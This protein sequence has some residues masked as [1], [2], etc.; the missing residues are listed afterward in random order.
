MKAAK[1]ATS[2]SPNLYQF[3]SYRAFLVEYL[4]MQKKRKPSFSLRNWC[5]QLGVKSPSTL[6]MILRG[7]R[8]PGPEL[9][10]LLVAYFGFSKNQKEYFEALVKLEKAKK[11]SSRSTRVMETLRSL[12]PENNFNLIDFDIFSVISNWYFYAIKEMSSREDFREDPEWISNQLFKRIPPKTAKEALSILLRTGLFK[13]D[14]RGFLQATNQQITTG[15]DISHEGLKRFH[16]QMTELAR[17]SIRTVPIEYRDISSSTF[18]LDPQDLP[19]FKQELRKIRRELYLRFEKP[20][21][22]ATYQLNF[23]LFPLTKLEKGRDEQ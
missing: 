15:A 5:K 22:K 21:A 16:E 8:N 20:K 7:K 23:Q 10:D 3:T 18:N 13:R 6:N 11:D 2:A 14:G 1:H 17:E 4:S 19:A 9:V 12:H